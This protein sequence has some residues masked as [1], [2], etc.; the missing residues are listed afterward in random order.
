MVVSARLLGVSVAEFR[1]I[2]DQR[3]PLDGLVVLFGPNSAGK[4]SILEAAVELLRA[5]SAARMDQ[6]VVTD[7]LASGWICFD[8]PDAAVADTLDA[9]LFE[10]WGGVAPEIAAFLGGEAAAA[11]RERIGSA[12]D[13]RKPDAAADRE[14]L[15][16]GVAGIL[17][18]L[19][20]A[21]ITWGWTQSDEVFVQVD[22][23]LIPGEVGQAADRVMAEADPA[24]PLWETALFLREAKIAVGQ[25][26]GAL[27]DAI[28]PVI[29]LDVGLGSLSAQLHDSVQVIHDRLWG[30]PAGESGGFTAVEFGIGASLSDDRFFDDPWLE[31]LSDAGEPVLPGLLHEYGSSSDWYRVRRSILAVAAL[32]TKEANRLAPGFLTEQGQITVE[33]L[34]V[35]VWEHGKRR[36][37]VT[38]TGRDGESR[39][40]RG[41]RSLGGVRSPTGLLAPPAGPP[42]NHRPRR[43]RNHGSGRCPRGDPGGHQGAAQP[44]SGP[45]GA[46][47][48]ARDLCR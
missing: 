38:F 35:S 20:P 7:E 47:R 14:I 13:G 39:D 1:S 15:A 22:P 3:L 11:T 30:D 23:A 29:V 17:L 44:D 2:R 41:H 42:G 21:G 24:D 34:P 8:L 27:G 10:G 48:C 37:R 5:A 43:H 26:Q 6:G 32:I 31:R 25:D 46:S 36:L 16:R 45:A 9:R 40:R 18:G 19:D 33:T 4:T 28:P 12:A